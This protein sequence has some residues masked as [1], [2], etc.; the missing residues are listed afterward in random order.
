MNTG[1]EVDI[2]AQISNLKNTDYRNTLAIA[3]LIEL[4]FEKNIINRD[5]FA[6]KAQELDTFTIEKL[7]KIKNKML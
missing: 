5:E 1:N 7:K 6:N 3:S 2:M 4:L